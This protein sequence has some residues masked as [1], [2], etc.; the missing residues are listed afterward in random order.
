[1]SGST[2]KLYIYGLR[3]MSEK[4]AFSMGKN[5]IREMQKAILP[6]NFEI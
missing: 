1:M 4:M 2:S 6:A 5:V 3:L